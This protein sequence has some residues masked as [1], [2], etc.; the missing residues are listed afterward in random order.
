MAKRFTHYSGKTDED[1][2]EYLIWCKEN[3]IGCPTFKGYG[4]FK[5]MWV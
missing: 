2:K 3:G 5:M 4:P 1:I